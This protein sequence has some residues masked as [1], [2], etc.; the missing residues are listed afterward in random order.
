M[1]NVERSFVIATMTGFIVMV[2]SV[3][4]LSLL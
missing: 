1:D 2:A 3:S 4:W